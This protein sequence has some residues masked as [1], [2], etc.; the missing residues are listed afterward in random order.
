[1]YC[2]WKWIVGY[3]ESTLWL[4]Y[5]ESSF[6]ISDTFTML[7]DLPLTFDT[8]L[9]DGVDP[10]TSYIS[11]IDSKIKAFYVEILARMKRDCVLDTNVKKNK[12]QSDP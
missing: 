9:S 11:Q 3:G 6:E 10:L 1:M 7:E 4:I 5:L 8:S 2:F 12:K